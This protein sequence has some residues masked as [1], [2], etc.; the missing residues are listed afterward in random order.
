M[1]CPSCRATL[2]EDARFCIECGADL[3][4]PASTGATVALPRDAEGAAICRACGAASPSYALFCVR[5]GQRISAAAPTYAPSRP[6]P[7][8]IDMEPPSTL[9]LRSRTQTLGGVNL[10]LPIFLVGMG[11]LFL[12]RLPFWPM[13]LVVVGLASF[14]SEA[15]RGRLFNALQGSF[16]MFGLAFLFTVPRLF[17]P[18]IIILVGVSVLLGWLDKANRNP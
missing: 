18:G 14:V 12:L 1:Q 11:L 3:R 9:T 5:C 15:L 8:V 7:P 13:I 17:I 6:V 10:W 4:R 2:P 16:W